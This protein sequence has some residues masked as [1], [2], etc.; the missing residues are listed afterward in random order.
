MI[1]VVPGAGIA[2]ET[3]GGVLVGPIPDVVR[4]KRVIFSKSP[5]SLLATDEEV[6]GILGIGGH[7]EAVEVAD[8]V[9]RSA[10]LHHGGIVADAQRTGEFLLKPNGATALVLGS[11]SVIDIK[12]SVDDLGGATG[13]LLDHPTG[14]ILGKIVLKE[15]LFGLAKGEAGPR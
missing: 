2:S 11:G 13:S 14:E 8:A 9:V 6:V 12:L 5:A 15:N 10:L 4:A 7:P 3:G 1:F